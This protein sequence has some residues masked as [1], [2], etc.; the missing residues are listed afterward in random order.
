MTRRYFHTSRFAAG[1]PYWAYFTR[2]A[3]GAPAMK[4]LDR[5]RERLSPRPQS[6][7][8]EHLLN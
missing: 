1:L 6:G 8:H 7:W 5:L 3:K 2:K 4:P